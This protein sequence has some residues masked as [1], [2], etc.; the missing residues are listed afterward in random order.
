MSIPFGTTSN[1]RRRAELPSALR[2]CPA[3]GHDAVCVSE[4]P[5]DTTSRGRSFGEDVDVRAMEL[6]D[7]GHAQELCEHDRR[8]AVGIS[9]GAEYDV[10]AATVREG[11]RRQRCGVERPRTAVPI[12]GRY[13]TR[14]WRTLNP[15]MRSLAGTLKSRP[16]RLQRWKLRALG[17]QG[18]VA[19]TSTS[20]VLASATNCC[21][22]N[23][24][25]FGSTRLGRFGSRSKRASS[26]SK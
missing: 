15:S 14:G 7:R 18:I 8:I 21:R 19:K 17:N 22:L 5:A 9:P 4:S 6:D 12:R 13:A 16:A 26:L 2:E 24:E 25:E 10:E 23:G 3:H 20:D 11:P 1:A